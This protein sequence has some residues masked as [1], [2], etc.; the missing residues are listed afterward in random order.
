M[1]EFNS[2]MRSDE[3]WGSNARLDPLSPFL[4]D[5]LYGFNLTDICPLPL[6]PTWTNK[7]AN[8][9]FIAKRL[10]RAMVHVDIVDRWSQ[11]RSDVIISNVSDH[12]TIRLS[13]K[14]DSVVCGR[15]FKFNRV[16]LEDSDY[17]KLVHKIWLQSIDDDR[18][19]G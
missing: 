12:I 16:W 15:P 5:L 17:S 7:R 18:L 6:L 9:Q 2:T 10:D 3:V 1:G 4:C 11:I 8:D 13:W 19:T 14:F